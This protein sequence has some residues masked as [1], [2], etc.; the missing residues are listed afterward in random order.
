VFGLVVPAQSKH[1]EVLPEAWPAV[2]MFLELQTQWRAGARGVIGL[3][4]NA[5]RWLFELH[6]VKDPAAL[7][8]DL[9]VIE[10]EVLKVIREKQSA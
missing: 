3:D 9:Q 7:L 5:A 8:S 4:Y 10:M 1:Y 2:T 6:Q